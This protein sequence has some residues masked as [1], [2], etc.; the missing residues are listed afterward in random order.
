MVA[1]LMVYMG[2][3]PPEW[4]PPP[5]YPFLAYTMMALTPPW[6]EFSPLFGLWMSLALAIIAYLYLHLKERYNRI[7]GIILLASVAAPVLWITLMFAPVLGAVS[8]TQMAIFYALPLP[9]WF[10][11][12]S[13]FFL[14]IAGVRAS[15]AR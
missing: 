12:A 5:F 15:R 3:P 9:G 4:T 14:F 13:H 1:P 7:V 10:L 11:S 8:I 2:H 6:R